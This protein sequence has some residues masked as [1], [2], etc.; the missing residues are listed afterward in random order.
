MERTVIVGPKKLVQ[1]NIEDRVVTSQFPTI[2]IRPAFEV[3]DYP[4]R[5]MTAHVIHDAVCNRF[6]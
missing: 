3:L 5:R 1:V 2:E 4:G 6:E